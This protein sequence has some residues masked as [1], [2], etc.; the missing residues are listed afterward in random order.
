VSTLTFCA[1]FTAGSPKVAYNNL[2]DR[3]H[4]ATHS[5]EFPDLWPPNSPESLTSVQ[6]TVKTEAKSLLRKSA[7]CD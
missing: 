4:P 7:G 2:R 5:Y 3:G 1:S 6:L